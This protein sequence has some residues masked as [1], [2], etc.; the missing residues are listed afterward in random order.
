MG[1][2]IV[3][4]GAAVRLARRMGAGAMI[5]AGVALSLA[6]GIVMAAWCAY[7]GL[8]ALAL[9]LPLTVSAVGNGLSQPSALAGG[10]SVYPRIAGTASGFV[11]FLQMA[12]SSLGTLAVGL[13]PRG[14]PFAMIA[15]VVGTQVLALALGAV[16]VRLP[17]S[18][19]GPGASMP[20]EAA[21]GRPA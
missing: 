12:V 16:A 8:S 1:G 13:L 17:I 4:N 18:L 7:P 10:L 14:G 21:S 2:Y 19:G 9:F 3:G 15:V 20:V 11:G 6:S 5:I